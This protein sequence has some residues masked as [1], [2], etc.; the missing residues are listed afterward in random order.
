MSPSCEQSV[1]DSS[2]GLPAGAVYFGEPHAPGMAAR[3]IDVFNKTN[4]VKAMRPWSEGACLSA[5]RL[6]IVAFKGVAEDVDSTDDGRTVEVAPAAH[7]I[8][9][10][11]GAG[12]AQRSRSPEGLNASPDESPSSASIELLDGTCENEKAIRIPHPSNPDLIDKV[13]PAI[14]CT[15]TGYTYP[16]ASGVSSTLSMTRSSSEFVIA[17]LCSSWL[18]SNAA[19]ARRMRPHRARYLRNIKEALRKKPRFLRTFRGSLD[20]RRCPVDS[21]KRC[22]A[23]LAGW[24]MLSGLAGTGLSPNCDRGDQSPD[25]QGWC[26]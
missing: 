10:D 7:G 23:L 15:S 16:S 14:R 17:T 8:K 2:S 12:I 22:A 6:P 5:I 9:F 21:R 20:R 11:N 1:A 25:T 4:R 24:R 19:Q 18:A 3:D 13:R 26:V